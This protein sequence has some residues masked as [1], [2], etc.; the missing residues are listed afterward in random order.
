MR[1]QGKLAL[2]LVVLSGV[3]CTLFAA[4]QPPGPVKVQQAPPGMAGLSA[5]PFVRMIRHNDGS[6]SITARDQ[7]TKELVITTYDPEGNLK[8]RRNYQLDQ[9]GKPVTFTFLN[10]TDVPLV[11]GE[12]VYDA[13][14]RVIEEKWF[15]LPSQRPI[16]NLAQNYDA[17]GMKRLAPQSMHEA[18]LPPEVVRWLEPDK[19][20]AKEAERKAQEKKAQGKP[21]LSLFSRKKDKDKDKKELAPAAAGGEN[22]PPSTGTKGALQNL[23]KRPKK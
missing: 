23:F 16:R 6:K 17:H 5:G 7:N 22:P 11:R 3:S 1:P 13:Q 8:L 14:D 4:N 2:W 12:Y 18:T 21:L 20:Q 15:E 10:G 19:A 9:Y